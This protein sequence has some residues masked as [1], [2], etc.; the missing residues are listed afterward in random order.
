[1]AT[2]RIPIQRLEAQFAATEANRDERTIPMTF[3]AGAKVLQFNWDQG[4]H[5]LT[6]SMD[7]GAVRLNRLNSGKAPFT[8]G[9]ADANQPMSTIGVVGNARVEGGRATA[10]VRFS[11]RADVEPIF[12]DVLDGILTNVSVGASILRMKEVTADGDKIKSFVASQW[13]PYAVALVSVGADPK[14]CFS[15]STEAETE[16]EIEFAASAVVAPEVV[17]EVVVEARAT[18]PQEKAMAEDTKPIPVPVAETVPNL[19]EVTLKAQTA[20]RSRVLE[21]TKIANVGK[22]DAALAAQ[23]VEAGTS[24]EA[25]R[26]FAFNEL[27]KRAAENPT[28]GHRSMSGGR[29]EA[30]T[31]RD[32]FR[33]ALLNRANPA[34]F[35]LKSGDLGYD[36]RGMANM[37]LLRVAEECVRASGKNPNHMSSTQIAE[38]AMSTSDFPYIL[39]STAD[40]SLKAGYAKAPNSWQLISGRRTVNNFKTQSLLDAGVV[41]TFPQVPESGEFEHGHAHESKDTFKVLTYGQIINFT[42]QTIINDTLGALTDIPAQLGQ[43]AGVR[44]ATLIWGALTTN[45]TLFDGV[46]LFELAS[47]ANY[48][49][50]G[51]AI[52]VDSI[53]V[54]RKVMRAQTDVAGDVIDNPPKFLVVPCGKE[55]LALQYT[56]PPGTGAYVPTT[57]ATSNPWAG[58]LTVIAEPRL[59]TASATGWYLFA[60]PN[61]RPVLIAVYLAGNEGVFSETRQGF[62]IDGVEW[63]ARMDFGAGVVDFRGAYFNAGA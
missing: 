31:R 62:D 46:A 45:G 29:D 1:M 34:A 20:E 30:D 16:C 3:Y 59:D 53:G 32:G 56:M 22:L 58:S 23:H 11:K 5:N 42:R 39:A 18:C 50:S 52:S 43:K 41:A 47:H 38:F 63:K 9:H 36:H 35:P 25:F 37:G 10:D 8:L 28:I 24:V 19:A 60:D 44:Q 14:A 21:I 57:A 61:V 2:I 12:A 4:L 27:A 55:Q 26:E 51:T 40:A 13:E 54:G 49:A 33:A 6:L 15:G 17:P 7:P 48:L